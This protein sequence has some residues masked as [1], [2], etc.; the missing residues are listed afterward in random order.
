MRGRRLLLVTSRSKAAL[1]SVSIPH[2]CPRLCLCENYIEYVH[3]RACTAPPCILLPRLLEEIFV[4]KKDCCCH[5]IRSRRPPFLFAGFSSFLLKVATHTVTWFCI[6]S[7][8]SNASNI[9]RHRY[10]SQSLV[11]DA[12]NILVII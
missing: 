12:K 5:P 1:G 7:C 9:W 11:H 6:S 2:P 3:F 4:E 8:V 10:R